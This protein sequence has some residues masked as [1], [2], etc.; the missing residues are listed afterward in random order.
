MLGRDVTVLRAG[1]TLSLVTLVATVAGGILM[2]VADG[3]TFPTIGRGLW[4]SVQTVTTVGYGDLVPTTFEG[5]LVAAFV[6]L[7]GIA[8]IA[9]LTAIVTAAFIENARRRLV[10]RMDDPTTAKLDEISRRL[11]AL[12]GAIG[13][14]PNDP[15]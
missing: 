3:K 5:R 10:D 1:A 11:A 9:V 14:R 7:T 6:M 15:R 13:T 2:R 8:F 4:W 12:E